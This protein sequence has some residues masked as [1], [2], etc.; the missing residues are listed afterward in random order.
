MHVTTVLGKIDGDQLGVTLPHEHLMSDAT[1]VCI[2]PETEE[3]EKV[4]EAPVTMDMLG[5]IK[6]DLYLNRD[7][8]IFNEVE[9]NASDLKRFKAAGGGSLVEV[10]PIGIA[11]DVKIYQKI[12]LESKVHVICGTGWY[13]QRAHPVY[14]S[15]VSV[16][17]LTNI[18]LKE[19]T[20]GI[21]NTGIKAGV[22]GEIGCSHPMHPDEMKALIA[23]AKAQG[24][25]GVALTIHPSTTEIDKYLNIVEKDGIIEKLYMSHMDTQTVDTDL[26]YQKLIMDRGACILLDR[27][28]LEGCYDDYSH[29][30]GA[31]DTCNDIQ[32]T[33]ALVE[34]CKQGYDRYIM[35]SQD[36]CQK[37]QMKKYGGY[38]Y[39]HILKH[40][41]PILK[42]R[43]ITDSQIRN[44]LVENPKRVLAR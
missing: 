16:E 8:L 35:L 21:D 40:I 18:M 29:Y 44:M 28:G 25:T 2:K 27:F 31:L 14:V 7:N 24:K 13:I 3:L 41:I 34:L 12:S 9:E 30:P 1:C 22:I 43:G 33:N 32:R 20:E 4:A 19:L 37:V 10:T 17:E 42:Y 38:G 15:K 26:K 5:E 39:A 11:R 23:A 36:T 6:R